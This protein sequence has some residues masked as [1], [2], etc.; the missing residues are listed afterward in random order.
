MVQRVVV[1]VDVGIAF[2]QVNHREIGRRLAVRHR[3]TLGQTTLRVVRVDELVHQARFPHPLPRPRHH[4]AMPAPARSR[5]AQ[6]RQFLLP[7]D[8]AGEPACR[9]GL[10]TPTDR[11][12]PDQLKDLHRVGEPLTGNCPRALTC[13][14]PST[15]LRVAAVSR[16]LPGVASCSMRAA[17]C[18]VWPTA[19]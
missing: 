1:V 18:V 5:P 12:G 17:R 8:E 6:G 19:E 13:T 11:T 3:G 2:E 7:P 15:N 4:L 14:R 16:I 9:A 10:Q